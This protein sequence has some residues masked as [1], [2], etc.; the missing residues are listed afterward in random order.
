[1]K[2]TVYLSEK[3]TNLS[4]N[5]FFLIDSNGNAF[6]MREVVKKAYTP[7]AV[8]VYTFKLSSG[9]VGE[10]LVNLVYNKVDTVKFQREYVRY[11][12][13]LELSAL[14]TE[15]DKLTECAI[16]SDTDKT[17]RAI[18]E[19][20]FE[21][22]LKILKDFENVAGVPVT[23][24]RLVKCDRKGKDFDGEFVGAFAPV[25]K[26]LKAMQAEP[27]KGDAYKARNLKPL[28]DALGDFTR[29]LWVK[30]EDGT[31]EEYVFNANA[32]LTEEVFRVYMAGRLRDNKTGN[33]VTSY[34]KPHEVMREVVYAC[35]EELQKKAEEATA[36]HENK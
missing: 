33:I 13:G 24:Q 4:T 7:N 36:A 17:A 20:R 28:R 2:N 25:E 27:L 26:V 16:E 21:N 11:W 3:V 22:A 6:D 35:F 32:R 23:V 30:S 9:V 31:C 14:K 8:K 18:I 19:A 15:Y 12:Y 5:A 10:K 34:K 29:V 1:M